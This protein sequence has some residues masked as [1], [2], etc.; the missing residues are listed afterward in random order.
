MINES[1]TRQIT[2]EELER[3]H[4]LGCY[5]S[6]GEIINLL[7]DRE[8]DI[9]KLEEK[10]E[11]LTIVVNTYKEIIEK[12]KKFVKKNQLTPNKSGL[13]YYET[14]KLLEILDRAKEKEH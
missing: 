4:F 12:S 7:L 11:Q 14:E 9:K 8:N 2:K 6:K 5:K 1:I 10:N 13:M 3:G